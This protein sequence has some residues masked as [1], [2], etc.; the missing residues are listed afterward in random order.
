MCICA[1]TVG[2]KKAFIY[3]RFEYRNL[4]NA[5]KESIKEVKGLNN[6]FADIKFDIRLGAGP[7]VAGEETALFESIEGKGP[8]PRRDRNYFP[9]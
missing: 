2:A 4:V 1:Q 9:T 5:L 3:L 6:A 8:R 7:Y